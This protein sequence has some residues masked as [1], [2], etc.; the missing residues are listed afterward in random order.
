M[1]TP[2]ASPTCRVMTAEWRVNA[3]PRAK[4]PR[5]VARAYSYHFGPTSATRDAVQLRT[6]GHRMVWIERA[7]AT[8]PGKVRRRA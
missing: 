4:G 5:Y 8:V 1:I 7:S 2:L 3:S 6:A